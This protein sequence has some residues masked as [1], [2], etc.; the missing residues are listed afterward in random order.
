MTQTI[1]T[2]RDLPEVKHLA[3]RTIAMPRDTNPSGDMFG[4]WIVSQMDSAAGMVAS[5]RAQGRVVTISIETLTFHLPVWVGDEVSCYAKIDKIGTTSLTLHVEA[6]VKRRF[7][8]DILKVT[9]GTFVF[10]ASDQA[11]K[12][13]PVPAIQEAE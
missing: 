3:T 7:T 4:G 9:E 11:Y 13:R 8:G 5:Q 1:M 2:P 6:W 10:V 12:P